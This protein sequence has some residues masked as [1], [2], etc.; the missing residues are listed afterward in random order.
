MN[1]ICFIVQKTGCHSVKFVLIRS[2]TDGVVATLS[3]L[4]FGYVNPPSLPPSMYMRETGSTLRNCVR[5]HS[6]GFFVS[7]GWHVISH[8][9]ESPP[10]L[11]LKLQ[12]RSQ[13]ALADVSHTG[14]GVR[15]QE[16][17][18]EQLDLMKTF[19]PMSPQRRTPLLLLC[20]TWFYQLMARIVL[21]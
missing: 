6:S 14:K 11:L 17:K 18:Q 20:A 1:H 2:V 16:S 10:N 9:R 5:V 19:D 3:F 21:G 15:V 7:A 13:M 8:L 12:R 4:N